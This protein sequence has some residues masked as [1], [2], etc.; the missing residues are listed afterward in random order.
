M[1]NL[2]GKIMA[3]LKDPNKSLLEANKLAVQCLVTFRQSGVGLVH[4]S[5]SCGTWRGFAACACEGGGCRR[6]IVA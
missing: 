2:M 4:M 1:G 5:V 6:H 3:T